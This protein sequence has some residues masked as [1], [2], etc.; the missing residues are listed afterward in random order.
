[1][2]D[3]I[4]ICK[5]CEMILDKGIKQS[6]I[7]ENEIYRKIEKFIIENYEVLKNEKEY[8]V[9][10]MKYILVQERKK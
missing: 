8:Q 1:M 4:E 3:R 7:L 5:K 9:L 2:K 10:M 6:E